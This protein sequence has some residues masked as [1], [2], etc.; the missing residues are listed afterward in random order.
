MYVITEERN[1][2]VGI[3]EGIKMAMNEFRKDYPDIIT[4]TE[5]DPYRQFITT[6]LL[7]THCDEFRSGNIVVH[8]IEYQKLDK[9]L[10][11]VIISKIRKYTYNYGCRIKNDVSDQFIYVYLDK[12]FNKVEYYVD[13]KEE[14]EK[15]ENSIRNI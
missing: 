13:S 1:I 6:V 7:I 5:E 2:I 4:K 8:Y 9:H 14:Y 10:L 3:S 11:N 15:I 12:V